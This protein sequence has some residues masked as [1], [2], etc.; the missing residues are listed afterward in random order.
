M[1]KLI[2]DGQT[3]RLKIERI[4]LFRAAKYAFNGGSPGRLTRAFLEYKAKL[5]GVLVVAVD[6]RNT[7]RTCPQCGF[8]SK[9][10][11]K[12]PSVFSCDACGFSGHAD[13]F[14]AINIGRRAS[15]NRPDVSPGGVGQGQAVCFS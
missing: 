8:V 13:H 11:R 10:N 6:P 12:S 14:A 1:N 2:I 3:H 5:A 4:G 9:S 7:S 15:V